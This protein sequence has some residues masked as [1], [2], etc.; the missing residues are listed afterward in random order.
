MADNMRCLKC[1][2]TLSGRSLL[3][4]IPFTKDRY[5]QEVQQSV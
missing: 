1:S 2:D 5:L 4:T 3:T